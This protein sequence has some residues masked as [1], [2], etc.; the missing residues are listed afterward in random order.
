MK[1]P[2]YRW[3]LPVFCILTGVSAAE[4]PDARTTRMLTPPEV[5]STYDPDAG[6]FNEEVLKRWSEK[7]ADYKEVYFS[8]HING[9]TVRVYGIYAVPTGAKMAPAVMHLHGGGQTV[10][11]QWLEAWT[12]RG[13]AALSCNYHGVWEN[14]ERFTLY[15]EA[16]KQGNHKQNAGKEMATVPTVRESSWYIWS[17]VARR[18]LSYLRQQPV[19]DRERIGAFGVSMG[20]TTIWSFAQ[21]PRLKAVCAIYGCGWNRYF[22]QIPRYAPPEKPP[23]MTEEDRVW[24]A[25]MAPEA[26]PPFI[27]CPVLF[28]CGSNDNHGNMDRAYETL[29]RLP[30]DIERRQ[31]FTPRFCHHIGADFDQD[32]ILWMDTWLRGG[33]AWPKSPVAKVTLGPDG[34]PVVTI[35]ADKPD[36]VERIAIYYAVENPRTV[37]RNWRNAAAVR[38]GDAWQGALP[39]L[40]A[41]AYLFAFANVRYK[42]GIHLSSNEEAV[43]PS[44]LGAAKAT[45][46]ISSVLYDGSDGTGM[47]ATGSPCTDPVPPGQIPVPIRPATGPD[48]KA[49]FTVNPHSTPMTY[50]L[51]DPKWRAPEGT[52]LQLKIATTTGETFKVSVHENYFWLGQKIYEAAVTLHGRPGWQTVTLKPSDFKEKTKGTALAGFTRCDAL[53]LS[54]PWKAKD[55]VLTDFRWVTK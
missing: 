53:Q 1:D 28:L 46:A 3:W 44:T 39:I 38:S 42:N 14:R 49:G 9:Q 36:D 34:V 35:A 11:K 45:D 29:A 7:G 2:R 27:K 12:A 40:D 10:N 17:A 6:E 51:G 5:W 21:D 55:I 41:K 22:R 48:G 26:Y 18:A 25:G 32:L 15:P 8:A 13:Y 23:E 31:A 47:W 19:V 37:S 52:A 4:E 30:E 54:G 50:Q 24:L 43:I 33:P 20:G 16:L